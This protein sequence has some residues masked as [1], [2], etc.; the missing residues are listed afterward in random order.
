MSGAQ[1]EKIKE[2]SRKKERFGQRK[3]SGVQCK[4]FFARHFVIWK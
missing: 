2:G 1:F 3:Y 4:I